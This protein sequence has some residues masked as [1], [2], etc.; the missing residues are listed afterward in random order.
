MEYWSIGVM[1]YCVQTLIPLFN[2]SVSSRLFLYET[3][4]NLWSREQ[5]EKAFSVIPAKA[6][7]QSFYSVLDSRLRGGDD[8]DGFL[9]SRQV[10]YSIKLAAS[11][12]SG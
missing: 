1:E 2:Y 12:A 6:G 10:S 9:R 7:I 4:R 11:A 3:S 8:R 5:S